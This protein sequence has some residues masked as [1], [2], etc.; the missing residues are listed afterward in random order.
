MHSIMPV[1]LRTTGNPSNLVKN[2][3]LI[4]QI[5]MEW[6]ILYLWV[7]SKDWPKTKSY[8]PE[9]IVE[10]QSEEYPYLPE[11]GTAE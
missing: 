1:F 5:C 11:L 6:D 7:Y 2:S 4:L 9:I 10:G 3:H 8:W